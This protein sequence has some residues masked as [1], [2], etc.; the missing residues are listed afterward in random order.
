MIAAADPRWVILLESGEYALMGRSSEP[1]PDELDEMET[2]MTAAGV[3]GWLAVMD[4]SE[5]ASGTA[6]FIMIRPL[7][8]PSTS[9]ENAVTKFRERATSKNPD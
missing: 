8:A 3:R 5:Y 2:R 4:R 9:F 7:L 1:T 6:E